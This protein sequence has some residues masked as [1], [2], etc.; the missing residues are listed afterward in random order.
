MEGISISGR[1][2][3]TRLQD[4]GVISLHWYLTLL[5]T[6]GIGG[7]AQKRLHLDEATSIVAK[8]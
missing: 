8:R 4:A 1:D 2:E 5:L 6:Q 7:S 3:E